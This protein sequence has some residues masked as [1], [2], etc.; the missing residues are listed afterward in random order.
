[1]EVLLKFGT[2]QQQ[3]LYLKPLLEGK[4]R[5][6]FLMT[7]PDVASSDATNMQ[8]SLLKYVDYEDGNKI[9]YVL[10]GKKWWS[11]G[12]M[13]PRCKVALV[14]AKMDYS[15]ESLKGLKGLQG[16]KD[17]K[18]GR[19]GGHTIVVVPMS[20]VKL[21]RPLTVFGYDHAPHGHAQVQLTNIHLDETNLILGEGKGFEISQARLGPG[22][23]HHCMRA[24]GIAARAH[25]LMV[26]RSLE[27]E[28][29]GQAL[30]KHGGCQE[31]IAESFS[32]LEAARLLTLSCADAIDT[33]GAQGARDSIASIKYAVPKLTHAVIDRSLQVHGG[34]GVCSDFPLA[35][36][37]ANIRTLRIAD[38]PDAVHK[39]TVAMV[40]VK[41]AKKRLE[42]EKLAEK[43]GSSKQKSRM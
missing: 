20:K 16:S 21:I 31:M 43:D 24:I 12:A 15:H 38:G 1:M 32:D 17:G 2:Q 11:S 35:E 34:A 26:R 7:E 5:S 30:W 19:H 33:Y 22:R 42:R 27:R 39:R 23:I 25:E 28:T 36:A 6:C 13:D 14:L 18:N 3:A 41:R 37:Y 4:I 29:F 9:K 8:T 40:E 10:N